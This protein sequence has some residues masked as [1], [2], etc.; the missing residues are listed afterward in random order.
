MRHSKFFRCKTTDEQSLENFRAKTLSWTVKKLSEKFINFQTFFIFLN[1]L[2]IMGALLYIPIFINVHKFAR[3]ASFIKNKPTKYIFYQ[4]ITHLISRI[5]SDS[6]EIITLTSSSFSSQL[7]YCLFALINNQRLWSVS[8]FLI[9]SF[10]FFQWQLY[11]FILDIFLTPLTIQVSYLL[12]NQRNVRQ[13]A[14]MTLDEFIPRLIFPRRQL[15]RVG[16]VTQTES[17]LWIVWFW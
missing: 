11:C 12:C 6:P 2:Q 9:Y 8:V 15:R 5:V 10:N 4:I 3:L 7:F 14:I 1:V 17:K 13:L 16:P